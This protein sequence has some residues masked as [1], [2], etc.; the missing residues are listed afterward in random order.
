[1]SDEQTPPQA[2]DAKS[3]ESKPPDSQPDMAALM[4]R[5]AEIRREVE[6]PASRPSRPVWPWVLGALLGLLLAPLIF[7]RGGCLP[8]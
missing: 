8:P 5:L 4:V 3:P 1:M 7:G 6:G 2:P